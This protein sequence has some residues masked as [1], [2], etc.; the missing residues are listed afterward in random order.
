MLSMHWLVTLSAAP[1]DVAR[2]VSELPNEV[3]LD[4]S[5]A[6]KL[7]VTLTDPE[8]ATTGSEAPHAAKAAI[9][10]FVERLNG[11]GKL[12]WGRVFEGV[13]VTTIKALDPTGRE[14]L[15]V[16]VGR[17]VDH[18]LPEDFAD[19]VE[20]L[21][22]PRPDPPEGWET[23]KALDLQAV[24]DLARTDAR[25]IRALRLVELSIEGEEFDWVTGYA[26]LE[27][28]EEDALDR[29]YDGQAL[30]WWSRNERRDFK[31]TANSPD[32]LG[33]RARHGAMTGLPSARMSEG[34]A[35]WFVRRVVARWLAHR[36]N[37]P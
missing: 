19:M 1:D 10:G 23:I 18:M 33:H 20:R 36:L 26:A 13:S 32:V 2:L 37:T 14:H 34:E 6:K 9:D 7:L 4:P 31:A 8:G 3:A 17:A 29:G 28:V 27:V 12:R 16:F 35:V 30:G 24:S 21:G 5:D 15:H 22:H 11:L 25:V